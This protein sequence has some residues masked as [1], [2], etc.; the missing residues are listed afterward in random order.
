MEENQMLDVQVEETK[1]GNTVE[2]EQPQATEPKMVTMT[3]EQLDELIS[4]RLSRQEKKFEEKISALQEAQKLAS[5]DEK[6]KADYEINKRLA[7]LE[8]REKAIQEREEA[9]S[10]SQYQAEI[11]RQL[12]ESNLPDV[13]DLLV[14]LDAESVKA[15]I[16]AMKETFA[17]QL[18]AQVQSKIQSTA[19]TPTVPQVQS[20]PLTMED[21]SKM[22]TQEIMQRKTEV[23]QVVK[24][25]YMTK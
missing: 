5:M 21:I 16:D 2:T 10:K 19:N 11:K 25:Y 12:A 4:K 13:S 3:Q 8:A 15:K 7:D 9:Y 22:S 23:D 14:G 17:H 18:N 20:K 1:A 6:E 24:E